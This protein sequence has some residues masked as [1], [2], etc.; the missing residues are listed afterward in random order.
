METLVFDF[1]SSLNHTVFLF[2]FKLNDIDIKLHLLNSSV[3]AELKK[4]DVEE[5]CKCGIQRSKSGRCRVRKLQ[6]ERGVG[7]MR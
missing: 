7:F 6:V 2:E 1:C 3:P 4:D 5:E